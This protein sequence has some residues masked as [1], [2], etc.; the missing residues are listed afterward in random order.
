MLNRQ[1]PFHWPQM[2][3]AC[4]FLIC[5]FP[6]IFTEIRK[7]FKRLVV[8]VRENKNVDAFI[9]KKTLFHLNNWPNWC[10]IILIDFLLSY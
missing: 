9:T 4:F 6:V 7:R 1:V 10:T 3:G 5:R 2:V 8:L